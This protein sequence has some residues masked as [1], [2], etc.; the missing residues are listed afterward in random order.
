M[1]EGP[2]IADTPEKIEIYRLLAFRSS[3]LLE[4]QTG[5]RRSGRASTLQMFNRAYGTNYKR[6][7]HALDRVNEMIKERTS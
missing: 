4:M 6:K 2:I 3:F 5:L 7:K 1:T